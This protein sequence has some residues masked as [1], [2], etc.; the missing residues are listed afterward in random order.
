M[1]GKVQSLPVQ[2]NYVYHHQMQQYAS[3]FGALG[4]QGMGSPT[5]YRSAPNHSNNNSPSRVPP[6]HNSK[7]LFFNTHVISKSN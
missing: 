5:H 3:Q 7:Q 2:P 6:M 4:P 1:P